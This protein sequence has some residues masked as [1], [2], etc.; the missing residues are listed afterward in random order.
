LWIRRGADCGEEGELY[1]VCGKVGG[2]DN[3]GI[4]GTSGMDGI[5]AGGG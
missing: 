5:T 4:C 3:C 2:E 1:G